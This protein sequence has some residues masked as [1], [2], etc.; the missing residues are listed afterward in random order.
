MLVEI[1]KTFAK[2][3]KRYRIQKELS[4][5]TFVQKVGL[6]RN[7]ISAKEREKEV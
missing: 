2:N 7:Y 3:S 4:Q 5:A 1:V 6:H